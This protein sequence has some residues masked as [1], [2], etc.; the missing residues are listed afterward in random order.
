M[1]TLENGD[2]AIHARF[3]RAW[4]VSVRPVVRLL[5]CSAVWV[6]LVATSVL[7][8]CAGQSLSPGAAKGIQRVAIVSA[9]G[10]TVLM[11]NSPFFRWDMF[12]HAYPARDL[13]IDD[14]VKAQLATQL[15]GRYDIVPVEYDP[16]SIESTGRLGEAARKYVRG[17]PVDA[18]LVVARA[19]VAFAGTAV[20]ATGLGVIRGPS[21]SGYYAHAVYGIAVIDGKTY[22]ELAVD[23]GSSPGESIF[24]GQFGGRPNEEVTEASWREGEGALPEAQRQLLK[25]V[26]ERLIARSLPDL[27]RKLKLVPSA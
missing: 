19:D 11:K 2:R 22:K 26:F 15:A 24:H 16:K 6:V 20:V 23:Y 18:Y 27:V 25:P 21:G 14:F 3:C 4:M 9:I 7:A 1:M 12:E 17:E 10:E 5:R 13:G 8:G